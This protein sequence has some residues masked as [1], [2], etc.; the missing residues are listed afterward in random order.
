MAT[1]SQIKAR[2]SKRLLDA[3]NIAVADED[4]AA[5]LNSSIKYWKF[6]RFWFNEALMSETLTIGSA[7]IPLP[8]DFL[9]PS[10]KQNGFFIEYSG[11]RYQLAKIEDEEYNA[12][13]SD[14]NTGLPKAYT[15]I[16]GAYELTPAPDQAYTIKGT[17]LKDYE[18]INNDT[19]SNDFTNHADRLL[20]LWTCANLTA[21]LRQDD[22]MEAYYRQAALDEEKNLSKFS[23]K[24]NA[25]DAY[26]VSSSIL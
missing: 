8:S 15:R 23:S 13:W 3:N 6:K 1:F 18:D 9:V 7:T 21:E 4:V 10:Q 26:A 2:V 22:K 16:A 20:M 12:R 5:A 19:L 17:Y 25:S 24:T 11:A 14:T